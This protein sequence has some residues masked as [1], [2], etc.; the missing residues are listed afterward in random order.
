M[1]PVS[2]S[3]KTKMLGIRVTKIILKRIITSSLKFLILALLP[4]LTKSIDKE[5]FASSLGWKEKPKRENQHFAP[6]VEV[7]K[8]K[9]N[10]NKIR[11]NK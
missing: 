7:P 4:I 11:V 9:T 3:K 5:S 8:N 1:A 6:W 2:G 10:T